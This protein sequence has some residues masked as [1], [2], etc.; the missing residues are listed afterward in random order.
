FPLSLL[1]WPPPPPS[2]QAFEDALEGLAADPRLE[3]VV[4]LISNLTAGPA[5]VSSLRHAIERFRRSGKR[6]I[7]Y[8]HDL[9]M[10]TYYLAAACDEIWVPESVS[11]RA[12]GLW[13]EAIFLRDTLAMIGIEADFEAI[14]EYK[15]SPDRLRRAKMTEP[16]REMLESLLDSLYETVTGAMAKGRG[17]PKEQVQGLLDSVPLTAEQ[18]QEAG[19]VDG[20]CYEDELPARLGAKD[21]SAVLLTWKQAQRRLIRSRR[22]HSRKSIGVISLEG[23]IV[24]GSSRRAPIPLPLPLPVPGTQAG[25]DTVVQQLRAA[26]RDK[27]LAAVVLHVD[28]PGGSALASDLVWREADR[29]RRSKPLVVYMGNVAASGGYYV[30]AP[31]SEIIAQPTTL[32]GSIGIWG[33]KIVTRG[34]FEK[35]RAGREVVSRGRSAGLYADAAPFSDDER[36]KIRADIGAGYA[37]FKARVAEGRRMTEEQVEQIGRGRVWTG[38]QALAHGL[39]DGLGDLQ[40]AVQ[41]ARELAGIS[42]H[43]FA[44]LIDIR[45]PKHYLLPR[46]LP[47][48]TGEW[49]AGLAALLREGVFALAPWSIRI[50]G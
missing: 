8:L 48:E 30:S 39:V 19:L 40:Q 1:P 25:S 49:L 21:E 35:L 38:E 23:V 46:P 26:S 47:A 3:G 36:A 31:A 37:R 45:A 9:G 17:L 10:W 14:A 12:A 15:V 42:P 32:T 18:A 16:H 50:R 28:T 34:L 7:A 27:R 2:V 6:C 43:R 20:L 13:S 22:W 33:G 24:T 29:L 44:H 41:R 11:F 4:L 5:T